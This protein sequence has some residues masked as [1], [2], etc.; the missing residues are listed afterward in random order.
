MLMMSVQ[1]FFTAEVGIN[2]NQLFVENH[3]LS[4][5]ILQH[6]YI[7]AKTAFETGYFSLFYLSTF[8][9]E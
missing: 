8:S 1:S 7:A 2:K 4:G 9:G 3:F 6:F 5:P